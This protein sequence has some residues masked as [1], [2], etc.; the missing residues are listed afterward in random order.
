MIAVCWFTHPDGFEPGPPPVVT[1]CPHPHNCKDIDCKLVHARDRPDACAFKENCMNIDCVRMHPKGRQVCEDSDDC[2]EFSC[3]KVHSKTRV[4]PCSQPNCLNANC[5]FLHDS[6]RTLKLATLCPQAADCIDFDCALAHPPRRTKL[7]PRNL[8]C[9]FTDC[10]LLHSAQ[11]VVCEDDA[12]DCTNHKCFFHPHAAVKSLSKTKIVA[13]ADSLPPAIKMPA[14][15]ALLGK[16]AAQREVDRKKAGLPIFKAREQFLQQ[17]KRERVVIVR[18]ETGSGK[19]TQLP[20]YAAEAVDTLITN[21]AAGKSRLV[22]CTQPR[23]FAAKSIAARVADEFDGLPCGS[24]VGY[25]TGTNSVTGSHIMYMTDA[26]LVRELQNSATLDHIGVLVID[27]A[28]ERSLNTDIVIGIAKQVLAKRPTDFYVVVASATIDA[29][30][31]LNYFFPTGPVPKP[32]EVEGRVFPVTLDYK[33]P[34]EEVSDR[35]FIAKHVVPTVIDEI[36]ADGSKGHTLV[37]LPGQGEIDDAIRKFKASAPEE[38]VAL[39]LYGALA[40]TA[41]DKIMKFDEHFDNYD[42]RMV[43]FT[44]NIAETSLTVPGVTLVVDSGLAQEARFDRK[45]CITVIEQVLVSRASADQRKGRAGRVCAGR[46]VRLF[47]DSDLKKAN[48]EP[49]ISRVSLDE[50]ML[51]L[52]RVGL[53]PATFP[54]IDHPGK[55]AIDDSMALLKALSCINTDLSITG[56]GKLFSELQFDPRTSA[57]IMYLHEQFDRLTLAIDMASVLAAPGQI[58]FFG[59]KDQRNAAMERVGGLSFN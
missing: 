11:R 19:T 33:P 56:R 35:E 17:L 18:A 23:A 39:P 7:C 49:E 36:T 48:I 15:E 41:Q 43:V 21:N 52:V 34:G 26:M 45:R 47:S 10:Q 53:N 40:G 12:D 28:H 24:S 30:K 1:A 44:T 57:L 5:K 42:Q 2:L 38:F 3:K 9:P 55:P 14:P 50:V 27:E 59:G 54:F 8:T 13:A 4:R 22:V 16:T 31:F 46:C 51:Q 20:Q 58:F 32:L 29:T 25:R 37:F 6:S